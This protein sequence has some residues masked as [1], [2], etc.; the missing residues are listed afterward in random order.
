MCIRDSP[1]HLLNL[2]EQLERVTRSILNGP[3]CSPTLRVESRVKGRLLLKKWDYVSPYIPRVRTLSHIRH[4]LL[5]K[6]LVRFNMLIAD[7]L[8]ILAERS[9][10]E[11]VKARCLERAGLH[12]KLASLLLSFG[13]KGIEEEL[14]DLSALSSEAVASINPAY[15]KLIDLWRSFLREEKPLPGVKYLYRVHRMALLYE[16]WSIYIF[17]T[18]ILGLDVD[19]KRTEQCLVEG[20]RYLRIVYSGSINNVNVRLEHTM[21]RERWAGWCT[22]ELETRLKPDVVLRANGEII[23]VGDVKYRGVEREGRVVAPDI[24]DVVKILGYMNDANTRLGFIIYPG[25]ESRVIESPVIRGGVKNYFFVLSVRPS[26]EDFE[27]NE[28]YRKVRELIKEVISG[29]L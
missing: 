9:I 24:E 12:R 25:E 3:L 19:R 27:E 16:M 5:N 2:S 1:Y 6:L 8:I 29:N 18:K 7:Q 10:W 11:D 13:I 15:K 26:T 23:G 20:R 4:S 17:A 22:R 28:Q 21:C 14:Y